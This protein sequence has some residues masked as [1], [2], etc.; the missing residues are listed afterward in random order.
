MLGLDSNETYNKVTLEDIQNK[1]PDLSDAE[2]TEITDKAVTEAEDF[3]IIVNEPEVKKEGLEY[4]WG[5]KVRLKNLNF[6][7]KIDITS[8]QSVSEWDAH[9]LRIGNH[10]LSFKDLAEQGYKIKIEI[11]ALDFKESNETK[12][13]EA[14][15]TEPEEPAEE[16]EEN[17]TY[18]ETNVTIPK[19]ETDS[20]NETKDLL[21]KPETNIN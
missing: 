10:L 19:N 11:P 17:E 9:T 12:E 1:L 7:A 21:E 5:Y 3:E 13:P 20:I 16:I 14:N 2:I 4:K 18:P 8:N 15:L 6:M